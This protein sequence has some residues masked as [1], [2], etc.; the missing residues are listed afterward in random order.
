MAP[1]NVPMLAAWILTLAISFTVGLKVS[2]E[3][4]STPESSLDGSRASRPNKNGNSGRDAGESSRSGRPSANRTSE[5]PASTLA[6]ILALP[7]GTA[8]TH[9]LLQL[10]DRMSP[11]DFPEFLEAFRSNPLSSLHPAEYKLILSAWVDLDP[12]GAAEHIENNDTSGNAREAVMAAWATKDPAAAL[13]WAQDRPD[14]GSSNNWTVGLARGLASSDPDAAMQLLENLQP[15]RTRDSSVNAVMPF[16]LQHGFDHTREWILG[17]NNDQLKSSAVRVAA[18]GLAKMEAPR[19]GEWVANLPET[20]IRRNASEE[21]ATLWARDDLES[22]R[23][24]AENL[25]E[26]TR[27]EAAEGIAREMAQFDPQR[28]ADWLI[29]MGDN[30]DLDGARRIFLGSVQNSHPELALDS[31][32]TLSDSSQQGRYYSGI[33]GRWSRNDGDAARSWVAINAGNLPENVVRRYLPKQ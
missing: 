7:S 2:P 14:E 15:G 13:A 3:G 6:Q 9:Q 18:R 11:A 22:A 30:P 33:L 21:V 28:T 27:T 8:Q 12:Y 31:V 19:A 16:V 26:D 5:D 20:E 24:W 23:E 17:L 4:P 25:P 32:S 29:T 10:L 1:K